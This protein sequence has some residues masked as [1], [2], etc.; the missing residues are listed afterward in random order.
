M[1][2]LSIKNSHSN[3]NFRPTLNNPP[4]FYYLQ[5]MDLGNI[6]Y[7]LAVLAYFI[8]TATR[9]KKS[10]EGLDPADTPTNQPEQGTSFEDLLREIRD[11]Q[12][13]PRTQ[14]A[15]KPKKKEPAPVQMPETVEELPWKTK[16]KSLEE[17]DDEIQ[18]YEG[19][20][21]KTKSDLSKTSKGVP[22]IP[23]V[24]DRDESRKSIRS[25]PYAR[26]LKNSSSMKDAIVL[27]EILDRKHF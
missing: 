24:V 10:E 15:P 17:Q 18:Y 9:K 3:L 13:K 23:S 20:F 5:A 27:K 14:E 7:I 22:E 25:N 1:E 2:G 6:L 12:K 4:K 8:Y 21:N 16:Y 19:A 11:Q 26:L